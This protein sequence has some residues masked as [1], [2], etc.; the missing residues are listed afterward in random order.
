M[1]GFILPVFRVL[2]PIESLHLVTG[3]SSSLKRRLEEKEIN[4]AVYV[5]E[6]DRA[7][8]QATVLKTGRFVLASKSGAITSTVITT[9]SRPEVIALKKALFKKKMNDISFITVES[10]GLA[11]KLAFELNYACLVPDFALTA[12][13]KIISLKGFNEKYQVLI[14]HRS[15]EQLSSFEV[16]FVDLILNLLTK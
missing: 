12:Y 13:H 2:K 6:L 1:D 10:W 9:E 15:E 3:T 4:I 14:S 5:N 7:Y 8:D 16:K 11:A